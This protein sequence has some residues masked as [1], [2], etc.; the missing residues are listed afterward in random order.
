MESGEIGWYNWETNIFEEPLEDI[1]GVYNTKI[2][3]NDDEISSLNKLNQYLSM[4]KP[5]EKSKKILIKFGYKDNTIEALISFHGKNVL[6][7]ILEKSYRSIFKLF[8]IFIISIFKFNNI[9]LL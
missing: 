7:V 3:Q 8:K 9:I 4:K 6:G 2:Y 1:F 5:D